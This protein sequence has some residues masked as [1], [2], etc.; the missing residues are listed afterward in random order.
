MDNQ[1]VKIFNLYKNDIYR[2]A[3]SYTRNKADADDITQKTF[4]KLHK[5]LDQIASNE[6]NIRKWCFKVAINEC[7]DLFLSAWKRKMF[8]ITN[9]EENQAITIKNN[10]SVL[11]D[12]LELLSKKDRLIIHL[13]YYEDC[14][15]SDIASFLNIKVGAVKT[16]LSRARKELKK[17]L[18]ENFEDEEK[19]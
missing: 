10:D 7:K 13:Y 4:I 6:D 1:F 16:R 14:K 3:Y 8:P 17:I 9:K 12:A 5:N 18:K 15:V 2:L 11:D 19:I